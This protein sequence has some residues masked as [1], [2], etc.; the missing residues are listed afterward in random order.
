MSW[1][2]CSRSQSA[3]SC[4]LAA[5]I[6]LL[7]GP[8]GRGNAVVFTITYL[9]TTFAVTLAFASG[10][11]GTTSSD[12]FF[13]QLLH[14]VLG[15]ALAALFLFLAYRSF[16]GRPQ[17]G[18]EAKEP[19]WLSAVDSFGVVKSAGLGIG[20]GIA[21][22]KNL[23]IMIAV[24]A[25]IGSERLDW[26]AVILTVLIFSLIACLGVIVPMLLGGSGSRAVSSFLAS[27]KTAL[28]RHSAIIMTVLFL[29]L[30]AV[31]LGKALEA[32]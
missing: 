11:K 27:T 29:V 19:T 31:Q 28:I 13:A 4:R 1:G 7:L 25:T 22:V 18:A 26:P 15:F 5:V 8:K 12:S 3:S 24:G 9:A 21:N 17:R 16:R 30:S 6:A 2:R 20:L 23:P 32:L 10:S 14:I